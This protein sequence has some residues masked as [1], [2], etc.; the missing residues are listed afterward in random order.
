MVDLIRRTA[1]VVG[2]I[3]MFPIAL[4]MLQGDLTA[5]DAGMRAA[6]VFGAVLVVRR[7]AG[8]LSFLEKVPI[9]VIRPSE[10]S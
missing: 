2:A 8:F 10:D 1:A 4:N 3:V 9:P 7:L 5:A 6:M